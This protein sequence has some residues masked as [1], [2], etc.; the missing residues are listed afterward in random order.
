MDDEIVDEV[1]RIRDAY[2]AKFDYDLKRIVEDVRRRQR[3]SGRQYVKLP[4]KPP[5]LVRP[6]NDMG[7]SR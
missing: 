1:H 7:R 6:K 5:D 3:E 2:A 4:P